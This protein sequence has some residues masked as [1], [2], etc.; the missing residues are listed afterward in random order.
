VAGARAEESGATAGRT[1]SSSG[2]ASPSKTTGAA[3]LGL[4]G[5]GFGLR[6]SYSWDL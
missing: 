6:Y 4:P 2:P 1:R 3:E 5:C